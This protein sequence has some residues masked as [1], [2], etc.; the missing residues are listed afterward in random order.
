MRTGDNASVTLFS[1]LIDIISSGIVIQPNLKCFY[2][3]DV[4]FT[5]TAVAV[6]P[7]FRVLKLVILKCGIDH[8]FSYVKSPTLHAVLLIRLGLREYV[9]HVLCY[10]C[11]PKF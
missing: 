7:C 8:G 4:V 9:F 2:W 6:F 5:S 10:A 3:K 1:V 11:R